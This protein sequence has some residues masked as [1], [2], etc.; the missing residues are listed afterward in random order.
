VT[1]KSLKI[2]TLL[3]FGLIF[4]CNQSE[5]YLLTRQSSLRIIEREDHQRCVARGIDFGQ[6]GDVMT[7]IYWRCR[8]NMAQSRKIHDSTSAEAIENN[9]RV[10]KISEVI[11][12]NL[13]HSKQVII[14]RIEKDINTFDHARCV[15]LGYNLD[16]DNQNDID[17]YYKCREGLVLNRVAPAPK[18]THN[19][20]VSILPDDKV[21]KYL[22]IA[23]QSKIDNPELNK[24]S[25]MTSLYPICAGLNVNSG[26]FKKCAA[27]QEDSKKCFGN[28]ALMKAKKNVDDKIYCQQQAFIQFPDNYAYAKEKSNTQIA[29]DEEKA[30]NE[31]A[32][33]QKEMEDKIKQNMTL[34]FLQGGAS[35]VMNKEENTD[36]KTT[37]KARYSKIEL[38]SLREQFIQRCNLAMEQKMP[39]F[40]E[41]SSDKCMKIAIDWDK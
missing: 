7:E 17:E 8:Y 18:V 11:L 13:N 19:Y 41:D 22:E 29:R 20:E 36:Q 10:E 21:S 33:K 28:I 4:S 23:R 39:S 14:S 3:F 1:K 35:E 6:W 27:A 5:S 16:S 2:I 15:S 24:V 34:R 38:Q 32:K 30:K 12:E 31:E 26:D 37:D 25:S 40:I 9:A